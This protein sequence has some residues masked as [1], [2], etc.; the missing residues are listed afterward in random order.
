MGEA[1]G[2]NE[3][4]STGSPVSLDIAMAL[5]APALLERYSPILAT[6]C[7]SLSVGNGVG[8]CV[9]GMKS[10]DPRSRDAGSMNGCDGI[11]ETRRGDGGASSLGAEG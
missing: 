8:G 11:G 4:R 10:G 6:V 2:E 9:P 5:A 7:K 3:A 1:E